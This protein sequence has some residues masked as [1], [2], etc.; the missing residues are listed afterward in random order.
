MRGP[1]SEHTT[2]RTGMMRDSGCF[3]NC[4][5]SPAKSESIG[6][7]RSSLFLRLQ[8]PQALLSPN[9]STLHFIPS[10]TL[11]SSLKNW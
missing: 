9:L 6:N 5:D 7:P 2:V 10:S 4:L 8:F 1:N 3:M 11:H